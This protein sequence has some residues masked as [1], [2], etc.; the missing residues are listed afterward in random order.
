MEKPRR[1]RKREKGFVIYDV[2]ERVQT[3]RSDQAMS[4]LILRQNVDGNKSGGALII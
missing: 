2:V 3:P 4:S 1:K